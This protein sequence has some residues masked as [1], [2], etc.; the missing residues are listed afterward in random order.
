[1][2]SRT[3]ALAALLIAPFLVSQASA[4]AVRLIGDYRDWSAYSASE[5]AGALCFALSK[6]TQ[7][8]P[9][10]DGFTEAIRTRTGIGIRIPELFLPGIL[11]GYRER[12]V[13]GGLMLAWICD[14]IVA[15]EDAFFQDPVIRMGIPGVEY[16]AHAFELP[17]RIA[18]EF[19]LF[20]DRM[21][22]E[23]A[24]HF[25]MVNRLTTREQLNETV[26]EMALKLAEK[27]R[28]GLWLTKQAVKTEDQVEGM[29]VAYDV[30][31]ML[32]SSV[33]KRADVL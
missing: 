27:P 11:G 26:Q 2:T 22:A 25:G 7:V 12:G 5:G 17:P 19:L 18:K 32:G 33:A 16:F 13:A 29:T 9:T 1:M 15:T 24:H 31:D 30:D 10:P 23:R 21:S 14:I 6:P 8:T 20:G 3:S 4:Q 28:L